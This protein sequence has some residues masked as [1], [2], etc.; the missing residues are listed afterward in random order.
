MTAAY[1]PASKGVWSV[2]AVRAESGSGSAVRT[3]GYSGPGGL[4]TVSLSLDL[5]W[6]R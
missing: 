4:L 1:P 5:E 3:T 2:E 6:S